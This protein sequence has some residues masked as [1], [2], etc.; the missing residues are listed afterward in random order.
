MEGAL[1]VAYA[2]SDHPLYGG[3]PGFG[4]TQMLILAAGVGLALCGFLPAWIATRI[5]ILATTSVIMLAFAEIGGEFV[6]GPRFRPIFQPDDRLI[7]KL[8]PNRRST[9]TR[10]LA[11]GGG[12]VSHRIN[13]EGFRGDEL[14]PAGE[15]TRIV[16]YGDS[17]IHAGYSPQEETFAHG[18][19][20][21]LTD[22]LGRTV[23]VVN[24]GVSSYGPDQ[25][26]LKMEDELPRLRPDL[27]VVAIFAGNDYG[28]LLRNK[29]F[30][31]GTDGA[32][33][34]NR[35]TLDPHVRM[36]FELGQRESILKRAF[37]NLA[38]V[39]PQP[40]ALDERGMLV[41]GASKFS[42]PDFLLGEA[43]REYRTFVLEHDDVVTNT[44]V[45]Y[46]SADL[47]LRPDSA[48]ALYKVALMEA[49]IRRIRD[50]AA[51]N[52][53]ALVFLFIPHPADVADS[54]DDWRID[55]TRFPEYNGRNQIAP[56]E[57]MSRTLGLRSLSLYERFRAS[58]A[59]RLYFH[60]G[61]D[62]WNAAGQRLAAEM[63]TEYLIA[64]GLLVAR[65]APSG[66]PKRETSGK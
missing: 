19:G 9:M 51:R 18:L 2:V 25:V 12:T 61:D 43:E 50:T 28:D 55:R 16:V 32:L 26:V 42:D 13:S 15:A 7:F 10:A 58:D 38:A 49:V 46:Y 33:V 17:F 20:A 59:N 52:G 35:W 36:L 24:A 44:H 4:Q 11:N 53:V 6:L 34:E 56:L 29:L 66:A 27:A 54:Y 64:Q 14:R 41:A 5:L 37:R 47:S 40:S 22:R 48:S 65:G 23:Q 3:E 31:L 8:I 45:D 60:G 57:T 39:R 1:L 30:R 21:L 63:M 62:H